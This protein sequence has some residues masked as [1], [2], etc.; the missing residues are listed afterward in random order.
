M[1]SHSIH[2]HKATCY[3]TANAEELSTDEVSIAEVSIEEMQI[4]S[5]EE[6]FGSVIASEDQVNSLQTFL[7][8]S[9]FSIVY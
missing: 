7:P 9:R 1:S 5:S 4:D 2:K 8:L 3:N 6:T